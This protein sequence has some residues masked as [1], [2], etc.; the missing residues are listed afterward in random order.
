MSRAWDYDYWDYDPFRSIVVLE[1]EK[2]PVR[3]GLLDS[4]G[5]EIVR[6]QH[7]FPIGFQPPPKAA[8]PCEAAPPP[9][10]V[11]VRKGPKRKAK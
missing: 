8:C 4:Q 2:G 6:L 5:R 9:K 10:T 7:P 3:T 1:D 11:K